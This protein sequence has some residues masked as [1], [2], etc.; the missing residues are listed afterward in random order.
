MLALVIVSLQVSLRALHVLRGLGST[1]IINSL[2]SLSL[3]L[4]VSP[5]IDSTPPLL[6]RL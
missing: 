3:S 5:L 1:D 6:Y 2:L 4:F